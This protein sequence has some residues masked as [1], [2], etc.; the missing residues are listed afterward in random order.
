MNDIIQTK[1]SH[2]ATK[3]STGNLFYSITFLFYENSFCSKSC[4]SHGNQTYLL[5]TICY[6]GFFRNRWEYSQQTIT[7]KLGQPMTVCMQDQGYADHSRSFKR[8]DSPRR[9]SR[10]FNFLNSIIFVCLIIRN[11]PRFCSVRFDRL[12]RHSAKTR[13][14]LSRRERQT[15]QS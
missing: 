12:E 6:A 8:D 9:N 11:S 7:G 13:K 14:R 3:N 4:Y 15:L 1:N 5:T 10:L 2:V